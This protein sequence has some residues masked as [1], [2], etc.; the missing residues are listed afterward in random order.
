MNHLTEWEA[1]AYLAVLAGV[2]VGCIATMWMAVENEID[3]YYRPSQVHIGPI[4]VDAGYAPY[5]RDPNAGGGL[6]DTLQDTDER[7]QPVR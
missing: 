5:V 3:H 7:G 6:L 1:K 2:I 4:E